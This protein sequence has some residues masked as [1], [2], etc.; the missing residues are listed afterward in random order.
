MK[1]YYITQANI[2]PDSPDDAYLAP[3]DPI[4][5]LKIIQ[6]LAGLNAANRLQEY[7]ARTSQINKDS[8]ISHTGSE[9]AELMKKHNI[10]PGTPEWF[11]LWF[12]LPYMTGEH[13]V[14]ENRYLKENF[15]DLE[16][17]AMEGGQ[18]LEDLK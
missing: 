5:E 6:Y 12:S 11:K 7:N 2:I 15:S 17:A 14:K 16:I 8:N 10:K 18:S 4:Q 1:Q 3:D 9:K 13:P